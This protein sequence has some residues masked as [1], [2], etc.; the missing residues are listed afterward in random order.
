VQVGHVAVDCLTS[1]EGQDDGE[2]KD[3]GE[4]EQ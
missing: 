4:Q 2:K 3:K 1:K